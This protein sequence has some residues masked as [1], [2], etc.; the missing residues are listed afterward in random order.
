M[1]TYQYVGDSGP[2]GTI[3]GKAATSLVSFYGAAPVV[4]AV[5]VAAVV[6][7]GVATTAFGFT[8][9]AQA[10]ALIAAVNSILAAL[11]TAGLMAT[12]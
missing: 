3:V 10:I 6:T 7:T 8:T 4:Q 12:A 2:D 9:T 11:K 1:P 5:T